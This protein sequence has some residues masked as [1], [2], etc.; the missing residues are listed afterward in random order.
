MGYCVIHILGLNFYDQ[1]GLSGYVSLI[2][3]HFCQV[4]SR[5][6]L[7]GTG[8]LLGTYDLVLANYWLHA[9]WY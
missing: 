3:C 4:P 8:K 2:R 5:M 7:I 9:S 1:Y 6:K